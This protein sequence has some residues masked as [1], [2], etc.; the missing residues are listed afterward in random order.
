MK[1]QANQTGQTNQ[2]MRFH[3]PHLHLGVPFGTDIFGRAAEL[4]ALGFGTP[5]FLTTQTLLV[6][7]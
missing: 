4:F 6:I 1:S 3:A 2:H 5:Y 7:V